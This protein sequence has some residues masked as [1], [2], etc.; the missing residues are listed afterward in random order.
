[1][2]MSNQVPFAKEQEVYH[3]GSRLRTGCFA[4]KTIIEDR[5]S[6]TGT[7]SRPARR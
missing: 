6:S 5:N 4:L 1:M 7:D 2:L 3:P